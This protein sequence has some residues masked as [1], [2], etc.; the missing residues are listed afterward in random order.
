MSDSPNCLHLVRTRPEWELKPFWHGVWHYHAP[1]RGG[2]VRAFASAKRAAAFHR[3]LEQHARAKVPKANPF[4]LCRDWQINYELVTSLPE[5]ALLDWIQDAGLT[6]PKP[7]AHRANLKLCSWDWYMWWQKTV[8]T[9]A[10][11]QLCHMWKGLDRVR[12][13][14]VV[15]V[16]LE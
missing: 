12:F 16:E 8:P 10:P 14:E 11:E 9:M 15:T 7:S 4:L 3:R 6:P 13:Y 5:F 1:K 2:A